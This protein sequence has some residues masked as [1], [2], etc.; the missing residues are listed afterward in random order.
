MRIIMAGMP[1]LALVAILSASAVRHLERS[2]L[3]EA[4][5][6]ARALPECQVIIERVQSNKKLKHFPA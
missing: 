4:N 6:D 5:M 3:A 2:A 1:F